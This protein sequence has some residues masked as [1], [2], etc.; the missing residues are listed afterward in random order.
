MHLLGFD[1]TEFDYAFKYVST[2][3]GITRNHEGPVAVGKDL[4]SR[5]GLPAKHLE[6]IESWEVPDIL[7]LGVLH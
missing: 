3:L 5:L 2:F 7:L 1:Q 6:D 4:E